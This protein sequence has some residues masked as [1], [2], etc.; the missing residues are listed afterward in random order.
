LA[1]FA[2]AQLVNVSLPAGVSFTLNGTSYTG[3]Q[4]L[5]LA[6]GQY[7][8][9]TPSPQTTALGDQQFVFGSWSDGGAISHTIT[10]GS[11][12]SSISGF[13]IPQYLLTTSAGTGG[14]VSPATGQFYSPGTVVNLT[15]TP[16]P[17]Y[18]FHNWTGQ[19]ASASSAAT[20]VTLNQTETVTAN[21]WPA[22]SACVSAPENVTA[23]WKG[24]GSANDVTTLYNAAL[25]GDVSF[26][27]GLVGQAFSFDGTQSPFVALPAPAFPAQPSNGPFSFET[28]FQTAGGNGGVILGQQPTAPYAQN[29]GAWSP[30]VYVGTEGNLY[31]E[32]FYNGQTNPVVGPVAVNDNQWHHVAITYDGSIETV[33]LDGASIGVVPSFT[34]VPNGSPLSYQLGTGYTAGWPATNSAWFT[35]NG[36][37]DEPTV[38]SRAL[39]AAEVLSIAQAASYGKCNPGASVN[40]GTLAFSNTAPGQTATLT[41]VLSNPGNAPLTI[42]SIATDAGDTNFS[43][44]SGNSGDC[45]AGTPL[46]SNASCNIR[47][48]FAPQSNGSLAGS[49]TVQDNSLYNAG[50]QTIQLAGTVLQTQSIAFGSIATQT[51]GVPL[52]LTATASSGLA[53]SFA[54]TTPG[55]CGVT[56]NTATFLTYGSCSVTAAQPGNGAYSAANP[57]TQTFVVMSPQ[58]IAF[59]GIGS[60]MLGTPLILTATASSGL[61][62]GYASSTTS[63]CSISG[64]TATFAAT[65]KCTIKASQAGNANYFAAAPVTQSFTVGKEAQSIAW[66]TISTQTV[67]QTVALTASASSGLPITYASSSTSICTVSGSSASLIAGGTCTIKATQAGNGT[68]ASQTA[69]QSFTVSKL[70]QSITFGAIA[71]PQTVGGQ[72][73]LSVSSTS[74]LTVAIAPSPTT[75]C[76]VSGATVSFLAAGTCKLSATQPGNGSY[77]AAT[78]VSQSIVV[79]KI[80]QTISFALIASQNAGSSLA[81]AASA[82][83]G[84]NVTYTASPASVCTVSGS[85]ASFV[86]GGTCT[87]T[88]AQPGNATY[89]AASSVS[90]SFTV[91]KLSQSITFPS[92]SAQNVNATVTLAA[93]ATSGLTVTYS[94]A[95]S[96][97]CKLSGSNASMVGSGTC[98]ITAS[99]N[100]TSIYAAAIPVPQSFLVSKLAQ[101]ISF[102]SIGSQTVGASLTLTA[103]ASS[104]L[105]VSYSATPSNVC[106]VSGSTATMTGSGTCTITASQ[107]GNGT[108][109]AA[110]AVPVSF[111]VTKVAQTVA[112]GAILTQTVGTPLTLTANASSGLTVTY[113]AAPAKVCQ[114]S[115]STVTMSAAGTC[116]ITAAQSGNA[117]Y[118][119]ASNVLQSFNVV[120]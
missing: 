46:Q 50:V 111:E 107:A 28:W 103:T 49:V 118:A 51:V 33:Y 37:I 21:F 13:F 12:A 18:V 10:V 15:A 68:Y 89:S 35:F 38:Y 2:A 79:N 90:Q 27:T 76:A 108:Y 77:A 5:S 74:G 82:S 56:G 25:G 105:A 40:P 44:L 9:S 66:A 17:G 110:P 4:V 75:V 99:Q 14:T 53:V 104:R 39:S 36:L 7:T 86:G 60:Q 116:N 100:G 117:E 42:T 97:V 52:T 55:V 81:L 20:T 95:P 113:T 119:A 96:S 41:A 85:T 3:P 78:A 114:V 32:M 19:V 45:A 70:A 83:S 64:N 22:P 62:V 69:S 48:Q 65:G 84:L 23:W 58:T 47:V 93:T 109:A 72:A 31:A 8:L 73:T 63:V 87:I 71:T 6:Q 94:A 88:A 43:V 54:S 1:N 106:K 115:G 112:F 61:P 11:L 67:Q 24:D 29:Q 102:G 91:G 120:Q 30:A 101:T 80:S 34:Q 92:I 26:A 98:T 57:V 59:P 16:N